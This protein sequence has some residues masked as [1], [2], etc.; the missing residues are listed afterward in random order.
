[1]ATD[2]S[3]LEPN[4]TV[5]NSLRLN[6]SGFINVRI[7]VR[8]LPAVKIELRDMTIEFIVTPEE[9]RMDGRFPSH[10][11]SGPAFDRLA[12][13]EYCDDWDRALILDYDQLVMGDLSELF[14]FEMGDALAAGRIWKLNLAEAS[15]EWFGHRLPYI[16]QHCSDYKFLL[17]GPLL[18]LHELRKSNMRETLVKVQRV[19]NA[20]EQIAFHLACENRVM[21][22]ADVYNI[23]PHWDGLRADAIIYHFTGPQKPWNT[24][25]LLGAELWREYQMSWGELSQGLVC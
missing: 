19:A 8:D 24:P 25:S 23:V 14:A 11:T 21:G 18:N 15:R 22:V 16:W 5:L 17:F 7:F 3:G 12:A 10:I 9:L 2:A 1:M 13:I 4:A 20:E 6:C